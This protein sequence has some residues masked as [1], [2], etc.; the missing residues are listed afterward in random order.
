MTVTDKTAVTK[1]FLVTS[2]TPINDNYRSYGIWGGSLWWN[3][4]TMIQI[5]DDIIEVDI[6]ANRIT[7]TPTKVTIGFIAWEQSFQ[8]ITFYIKSAS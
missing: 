3:P 5:S 1:F 6:Q 7:T 4:W 8:P 2:P